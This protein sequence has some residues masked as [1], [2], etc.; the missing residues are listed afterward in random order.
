MPALRHPAG[1]H[2]PHLHGGQRAVRASDQGGRQ[3]DHVVPF[4]Q[5]RRDRVRK[6][7]QADRRSAQCTAAT[8]LSVTACRRWR[9]CASGRTASCACCWRKC[10]QRKMRVRVAGEVT[11][12]RGQL[13]SRL[14]Q[15]GSGT[16]EALSAPSG[17]ASF[18]GLRFAAL[19]QG[20]SRQCGSYRPPAHRRGRCP[21]HSVRPRCKAVESANDPYA[22]TNR[23]PVPPR[24]AISS[25][26]SSAAAAMTAAG[27]AARRPAASRKGTFPLRRTEGGMAQAADA[28][29]VLHPARGRHRAAVHLRAAEGTS[30]GHLHLRSGRHGR[31]SP[32]APSST[33]APAGPAS[34][35]P[36]QG[37]RR[38]LQRH[39]LRHDPHRSR[40]ARAAGATSATCSMMAARQRASATASMAMR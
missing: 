13:R 26:S 9:R 25:P 23:M 15:A 24:A 8:S 32:P 33:A 7:G 30:Q 3:G 2:A 17:S 34:S 10:T 14:P 4:G 27:A 20:S 35:V 6:P 39:L 11:R 1:A 19:R 40:T 22:S 21:A 18:G 38:H 12:V 29:A 5:P 36:D 16:G 31:C 37:R 28:G